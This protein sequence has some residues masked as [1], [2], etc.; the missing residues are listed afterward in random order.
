DAELAELKRRVDAAVEG[1]GATLFLAGEPGIG[2]TR[3]ATEASVYARLRG[4]KVLTGRCDEEGG[5]PYQPFVEAL[6]EYLDA[7]ESWR[8]EQSMPPP[9]ACELV[10]LV[11]QI[12][13]KV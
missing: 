9:V 10:R 13:G 7:A 8:V 6:R 1:A 3:L 11:P 2:K 5:A 4:C 12:A